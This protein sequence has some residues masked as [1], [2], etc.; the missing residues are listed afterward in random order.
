[1]CLEIANYLLQML[2]KSVSASGKFLR[3]WLKAKDG[4]T[5]IEFSM[6]FMPYLMMSLAI[7]E[8]SM[9]YASA[10]LLE[11]ATTQAARLIRTGQIQQSGTPDPEGMFRTELCEL[12]AILMACDDIQIEVMPMA[13][14]DDFED[15]GPQFDEDGNLI[16]SGF[17][18]GGSD[19]RVLV[20]VAYRYQMMTPFIGQLLAGPS[21]ERL[22]MSTIVL[23]SEPYDFAEAAGV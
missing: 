14:Y 1:L 4:S 20:R 10:S 19:D 23:Q 6:L 15:M 5:A 13:S 9:M 16:S 22:F 2:G 18:A 7:L 11:G 12:A 8:M 3:R 21:A 17:S